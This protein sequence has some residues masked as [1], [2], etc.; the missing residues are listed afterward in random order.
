VT[1]RLIAVHFQEGQIRPERRPAGRDRPHAR[2]R[3]QLTQ[4]EGQLEPRPGAARERR[5]SGSRCSSRPDAVPRQQLDTQ[6]RWFT[7]SKH[8][9][10][11]PGPIEATK[12]QLGLL[13]HHLAI[14]GRVGLRL[15][16]PGTSCTPPNGRP[17][18]ITQLQADHRDFTIPEDSISDGAAAAPA[19]VR[20]RWRPTIESI[21][22][23]SPRR[24]AHDRQPGRSDHGHGPPQAQFPNT[25]YRLFPT[26]FVNARLLIET[27]RGATV[28]PTAAIQQSPRGSFST[29]CGRIRP[30]GSAS[31]VGVTDG[32]DVSI[33]RGLSS[34]SRSWSKAQSGSAT[35][36]PSSCA[37]PHEPLAP[38]HPAAVATRCSSPR[39]C[40]RGPRYRCAV[41]ALPEVDYPTIPGLH[42]LRGRARTLRRRRSPPRSSGSSGT[43][44]AEPR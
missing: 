30:S 31:D 35:G 11:R 24:T 40:W 9:Q 13:S 17:V 26:Q 43:C 4:F 2:S 34:G 39:C 14:A 22:E 1:A 28:V 6:V 5:S 18:I 25:D 32:D 3:A 23:S 12:V 27:R 41:S 10:E 37:R 7:S 16:A 19:R 44:R 8:G 29:R 20:L 21:G 33:E 36:P 42:V 15:V 38:V